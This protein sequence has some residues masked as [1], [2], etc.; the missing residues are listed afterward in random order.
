MANALDM[1]SEAQTV[2]LPSNQSK[3]RRLK[4]TA[5]VDILEEARAQRL[6][7]ALVI[8][9]QNAGEVIRH[10]EHFEENFEESNL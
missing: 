6:D 4:L 10:L 2:A 8:R 7:T 1:S 5:P 3:R 9:D